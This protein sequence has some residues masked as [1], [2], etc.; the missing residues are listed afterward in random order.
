MIITETWANRQAHN[1]FKNKSTIQSP[2]SHKEGII[3]VCSNKVRNI[4]PI[5]EEA[6]TPNTIATS[7]HIGN[8]HLAV[9]GHYSAPGKSRQLD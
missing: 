4:Q 9:I 5:I 8:A 2:F 3:I 7:V 6:W 1:L